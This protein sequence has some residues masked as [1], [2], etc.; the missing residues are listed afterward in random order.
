MYYVVAGGQVVEASFTEPLQ[1]ELQYWA[2]LLQAHVYVI[3]GEHYGM[4]A[5]PQSTEAEEVKEPVEA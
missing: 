5:E 2:D 1:S 3:R 4:T